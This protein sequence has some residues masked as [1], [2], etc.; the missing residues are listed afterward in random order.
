M[1]CP[2]ITNSL[3]IEN[4]GYVYPCFNTTSKLANTIVTHQGKKVH[5]STLNPSTILNWD[6][7]VELRNILSNNKWPLA[8]SKCRLMEA[9]GLPST[10]Q[11]ITIT[12]VEPKLEIIHLRLGNKCNLRCVMCGPN[13]SNQWYDDYVDVTGTNTFKVANNV[14]E[15]VKQKDSYQLTSDNFNFSENEKLADIIA[16]QSNDVKEIHFHGGE[17]LLSKS[18]NKLIELL[19][20]KKL[21][22]NIELNY[23]TNATIYN[24]Q[25]FQKLT[26]FK[27]VTFILSL[28]GIDKVNDAVRWPSKWDNI[29]TVIDKMKMFT[30]SVNHT[31]HMLN[32]EHLSSFLDVMDYLNLATNVS[33]VLEPGYM[34]LG[35]L[36]TQT[37]VDRLITHN[38]RYSEHIIKAAS[39]PTND[40]STKI[41]REQFIRLWNNFSTKQNQNWD[42]LFPLALQSMREW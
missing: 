41:N 25:L 22:A 20:E 37:Q 30:L 2:H 6:S 31:M 28:D 4:D 10:R 42:K 11:N 39:I 40:D 9:K 16:A 3:Y 1:I 19:I 12:T 15:L 21:A 34:S 14:Y 17:P 38:T 23:H 26:E 35:G 8:C 5:A 33:V 32:A 18:H 24:E 29:L 7:H 36:L 13:A 27:Q